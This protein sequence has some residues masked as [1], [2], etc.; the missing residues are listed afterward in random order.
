MY[1]FPAIVSELPS[2]RESLRDRLD[3]VRPASSQV[4]ILSA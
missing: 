4:G 3:L 1:I 2:V